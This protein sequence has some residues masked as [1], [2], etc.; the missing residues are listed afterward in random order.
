ML[1]ITAIATATSAAGSRTPIT[2]PDTN[3]NRAERTV[4]YIRMQG[5]LAALA[6]AT[7]PARVGDALIVCGHLQQ[8]DMVLAASRDA[9]RLGVRVS[10]SREE[11][12][13]SCAGEPHASEE[14][15]IGE[16]P[17]D[18]EIVTR[19]LRETLATFSP[20]VEPIDA[21]G[22]FVELHGIHGP[23]GASM[24][25]RAALRIRIV[26]SGRFG[27]GCTIGIGPNKLI[28]R[29]ASSLDRPDAIVRLDRIGFRE[30]SRTW[31]SLP[32]G[33]WPRPIR[34]RL[35]S[36]LASW[37]MCCTR[38][39]GDVTRSQWFPSTDRSR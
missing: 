6:A 30:G 24:A 20:T 31:A 1:Q 12:K 38:V 26:V 36:G 34:R 27:I 11:A 15:F 21:H 35:A 16:S 28:A 39:P 13:R 37:G 23:S 19:Y 29:M 5:L 22:V 4:L 33:S 9:Q 14:N 17:G 3:G 25:Q 8:R 18:Y 32:S 2:R 7:D 10:M